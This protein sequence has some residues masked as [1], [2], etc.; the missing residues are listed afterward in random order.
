MM[1]ITS[2]LKIVYFQNFYSFFSST[3]FCDVNHFS[4]EN[5][6]D[7][8]T[9]ILYHLIRIILFESI[10]LQF[11][12]H[13]ELRALRQYVVAKSRFVFVGSRWPPQTKFILCRFGLIYLPSKTVGVKLDFFH[14][15]VWNY[16]EF[17]PVDGCCFVLWIYNNDPHSQ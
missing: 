16:N 4:V 17:L 7:D 2:F 5:R 11:R 3:L 1:L 6:L 15:L 9:K 10:C 14:C 8:D 13:N 12:I